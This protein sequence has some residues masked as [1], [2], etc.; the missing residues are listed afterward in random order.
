MK[1]SFTAHNRPQ[2]VVESILF[3]DREL[4]TQQRAAKYA[5]MS[6][7]PYR[8]FRG[9]N[10][11]FWYDFFRD[12]QFALF[13]GIPE[14]QTWIQGDA[15]VYNF[16]V[17]GNS[18]GIIYGM[19]DFDD[20]IVA[21]YQY[22]LWRLA[23]SM[24]LDCRENGYFSEKKIRKFLSRLGKSYLKEGAK[25]LSE[26]AYESLNSFQ[27][28]PLNKFLEK[29][30]KKRD[31]G[32]LLD[33]WTAIEDNKRVFRL[34]KEKL[35]KVPESTFK[36]LARALDEHLH[37]LEHPSDPAPSHFKIKDVAKRLQAGTGSLG[38]MRYYALI[39]GKG[40]DLGDDVILDIKEQT[41]PEACK[42]MSEPELARYKLAFP[43]EGMRH[44]RAFRAISV[45]PDPYLGWMRWN[46]A[47]F[48][49]RERSPFKED[50]PTDK[51]K[52]YDDYLEMAGQ[53]GRLLARE[54]LRGARDLGSH[55]QGELSAHL[56][57]IKK[58]NKHPFLDFLQALALGY[59]DCVEL[60][61]QTFQKE[62]HR[63]VEGQ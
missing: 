38:S 45:R 17:F 15:H 26:S 35:D 60:D 19:D 51:I 28:P 23:V 48:S 56:K 13:G 59:A 44:A 47:D 55:R 53:W 7:S 5:K 63:L 11:L 24:V 1:A 40:S 18:R 52:D 54:H 16:G 49:I 12:W 10:N 25:G 29:I 61:F 37:T 22:D 43:D 32:D 39:E 34:E 2:E 57:Q 6:A 3:N 41:A 58:N 62:I 36:D 42:Q 33:K 31:R 20:S 30:A 21:D 14:T 27:A 50:F 8:F 9:S 46:N 4:N